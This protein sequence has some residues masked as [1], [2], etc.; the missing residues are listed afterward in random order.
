MRSLQVHELTYENIRR[1][2]DWPAEF[3][4]DDIGYIFDLAPK[5]NPR[6]YW[7]NGPRREDGSGLRFM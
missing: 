1:L 3:H 4:A 2:A 7:R 6:P 5:L